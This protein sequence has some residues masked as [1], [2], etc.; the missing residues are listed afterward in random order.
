MTKERPTQF[1]KGFESLAGFRPRI[2]KIQ[3]EQSESHNQETVNAS[4]PDIGSKNVDVKSVEKAETESEDFKLAS[5]IVELVN[6]KTL[7]IYNN[8][9][10]LARKHL[11]AMNHGQ[12]KK[13]SGIA[14]IVF[15][16]NTRDVSA[17]IDRW[18]KY[19]RDIKEVDEICK[20]L[21]LKGYKSQALTWIKSLSPKE[22]QYGSIPGN[23][24]P[25]S[26]EKRSYRLK[27]A[28]RFAE[29]ANTTVEDLA[30]ENNLTSLL[31]E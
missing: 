29:L 2:E 17:E 20:T 18:L 13:Y 21:I 31:N 9:F 30:K 6:K 24:K 26:E 16:S 19:D 11:V 15:G 27:E 25:T 14:G 12:I 5:R 8:D 10:R 7:E 4:K 22:M 28:R 3:P 1:G 23:S